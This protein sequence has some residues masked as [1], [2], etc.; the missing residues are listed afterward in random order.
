MVQRFGRRFCE[1]FRALALGVCMSIMLTGCMGEDKNSEGSN[2]PP[3]QPVE[4]PPEQ[5]EPPTVENAA[6][7]V[8]NAPEVVAEVG[9][10]YVFVPEV[11]DPDGD[12]LTF[13]V[14]NRPEWAEFNDSNGELKGIP[15][16]GD[17]GES[18]EIE[19]AVSDGRNRVVI[20][21]F[22][23]R[24]RPR[25]VPPPPQN[26]APV[27]SGTPATRVVAGDTY[28]FV[29]SASDPDGDTLSFSIT[30]RPS[31]ARFSTR[32]GRLTGTPSA[33]QVGTYRNIRI[34]VSDGR[35]TVSLPP[36]S[37]EVQAR[38]NGAPTISGNPPTS[39]APGQQYSFRPTA[40]DPD[41]DQLSFTIENKPAW[42]SFSTFNGRLYGTPSAEHA[43]LYEDI[44]IRVSDGKTS[45]SLPA[46]SIEVTAPD[47][48]APTIS[49]RP[50]SSVVVGNVYSFKP[51]AS[52]PDGD[53]LTFSIDNQPDWA[54]FDPQTGT[55]TGTPDASHVGE[56]TNIVIRVSDGQLTASLAPFSISVQAIA[57]GT[58]TV[59][60]QAPTENT[61]GSPL[62]DLAGFRIYY[63][64][65][66]NSLTRS[67]QVANPGAASY[68]IEN[69]GRGTWYF[70]VRAYRAT[71]Q[72]SALSNIAHK[73]IN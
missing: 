44:V 61:D 72:E 24:V 5:P 27:I 10:S 15:R 20:G 13:A 65:S 18:E 43:G 57:N 21:P 39:V 53:E 14:A 11:S 36:F 54:D 46:F 19:I 63:G 1:P 41:G 37:I 31:W 32:T 71:G 66:Q 30:N 42:A 47:N 50:A 12:P 49:G 16:D 23:I 2:P 51:T 22:R 26:S 3:T 9:A 60:W 28:T 40:S 34:S 64:T 62:T 17:V 52:D 56:Y 48:A 7:E 25:N 8:H 35:Q 6:P 73:T 68:V 33:S 55:L 69:L 70:G 58:A 67:V 38:P 59:R 45:A 29:P 4:Q